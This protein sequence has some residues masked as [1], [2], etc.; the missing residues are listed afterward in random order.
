MLKIFVNKV[1][2]TCEKDGFELLTMHIKVYSGQNFIIYDSYKWRKEEDK[3][4]YDEL[5]NI[6]AGSPYKIFDS[7]LNK[8]ELLISFFV[9]INIIIKWKK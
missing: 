5:D 6:S 8:Y 1:L 7:V 9:A 4:E 3:I 2:F